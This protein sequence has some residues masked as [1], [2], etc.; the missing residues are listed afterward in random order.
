M[1]TREKGTDEPFTSRQGFSRPSNKSNNQQKASSPQNASPTSYQ[2]P[3]MLS[4]SIPPLP[5]SPSLP[6]SLSV[7]KN[8][9]GSNPEL[10]QAGGTRKPVFFF[11]EENAVFLVKGNFMTLAAKPKHVE[12][13]EW[14]AHQIVEQNRL[15]NTMIVI[16]QEI[17]ANTKQAICNPNSCPTMFANGHTYTWFNQDK[18]SIKVPAPQYM[19]LVQ[20]WIIGKIDN[21]NLFPTDSTGIAASSYASG[22][23]N[24]PGSSTPIAAGPTTLS[25]PLATLAGRDWI[26]KASG[27][28]E[29]FYED[30]KNIMRQMFRCYAHLYWGHWID[31]F[32][33]LGRTQHLNSCFMHFITV[34]KL[35][36]LLSEKDMEPMQPLIDIWIAN[37]SISA[38]AMP[39]SSA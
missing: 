17:D 29:I 15:L 13:G 35:F 14:L 28:P 18:I 24:T 3:A 30:C 16:V 1:N 11:R 39:S 38:D 7:E 19:S 37:K 6:S 8:L 5:N 12:V 2:S 23:L 9:A 34:A 32:Y 27:F 21:P 22:G 25:T 4:P 26:G 36:D 10:N 33:H 20:K 31:P